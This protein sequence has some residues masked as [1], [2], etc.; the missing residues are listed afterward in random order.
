MSGVLSLGR[1]S[2]SRPAWGDL[3]QSTIVAQMSPV[4]M[5]ATR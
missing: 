1:R 2:V 3:G 5:F 4:M